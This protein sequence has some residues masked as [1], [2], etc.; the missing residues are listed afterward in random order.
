LENDQKFQQQVAEF[1]VS[2]RVKEPYSMW[3]KMIRMGYSH[4]LQV[5]DAL[6]LRI[7]LDAKKLS[8]DEPIE[9]TEARERALCYYAQKLCQSEFKPLVDN[10]RFKDY[11]AQ[12]KRN[13]YQSLHY[14][15][16]TKWEDEDWS[17]EVQ[18]RS[19][20]MHGV[21]EF[22][23]A[24]HCDYKTQDKKNGST[25]TSSSLRE[26]DTDKSSDAYIR[27]LQKWRCEQD[28]Q[29]TTML[30]TLEPVGLSDMWHSRGRERFIRKRTERL[31][32]Y[33][34]SLTEVQSDLVRDHVFVFLTERHDS[35]DALAPSGEGK[36]LALPAGACVLDAIRESE[37]SLGKPFIRDTGFALNGIET[38]VTRQLQNG[39]VLR[40]KGPSRTA[41][42]A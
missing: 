20:A 39:D 18:V 7:V 12:P 4:I 17:L 35:G 37:R 38:T 40:I 16:S 33:L 41:I 30:E 13:G 10:P 6:A 14:T 22:G 24:C 29:Q 11:I 28:E 25:G 27:N 2:A 15:A 9:V 42:L 26:E 34:K 31:R 21:A 19:G 36:V 23:I 3:K 8:K 5:P 32:P 1:T